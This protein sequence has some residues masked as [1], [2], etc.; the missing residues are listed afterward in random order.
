MSE[1]QVQLDQRPGFPARL[2]RAWP[3]LAIAVGIL[4][5][6]GIAGIFTRS[7]PDRQSPDRASGTPAGS[8]GGFRLPELDGAMVDSADFVGKLVV[9]DFW[10]TWCQPCRL[11][12]EMLEQLFA[13]LDPAAVQFLAINI[14]E[15]PETVRRFV[16]QTPF[17][18]PVLLDEASLLMRQYALTGLP[19]VI[20]FDRQSEIAFR[21]AGI[22]DSAILRL[23]L[24]KVGLEPGEAA[25]LPA[26]GRID[27]SERPATVR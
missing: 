20:I 17:S 24:I 4:T 2:I 12:A 18:Y 10:A 7:G 25:G 8:G 21:H 15:D 11:Q 19:T 16:E 5:L 27:E 22:V 26:A 6:A 23:E 13:D 14:G 1:R 9:A 3:A